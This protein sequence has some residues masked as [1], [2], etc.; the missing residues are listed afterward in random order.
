M[1]ICLSLLSL[2][3]VKEIAVYLR[4][5]TCVCVSLCVLPCVHAASLCRQACIPIS[6]LTD[7]VAGEGAWIP[8]IF[9]RQLLP[10]IMEPK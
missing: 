8:F 3:H 1:C 6:D 10:G 2:V 7:L 4:L 5:C 9:V